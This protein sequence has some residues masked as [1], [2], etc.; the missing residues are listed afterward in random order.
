MNI[1]MYQTSEELMA[2]AKR[3]Y[4]GGWNALDEEAADAAA[5]ARLR[6]S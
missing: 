1:R 2:P 3:R 4:Y 6:P 5:G